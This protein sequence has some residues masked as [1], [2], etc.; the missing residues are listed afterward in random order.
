MVKIIVTN[1]IRVLLK[2]DSG[3]LIK[4]VV[5]ICNPK[6]FETLKFD[7]LLANYFA[8]TT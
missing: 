8:G 6:A 2:I 1:V 3:P 4:Y 7:S 5:I